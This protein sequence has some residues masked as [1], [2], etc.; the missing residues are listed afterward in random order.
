MPVLQITTNRTV[1]NTDQLAEQASS[2]TAEMLGK[3]ESYVMVSINDDANL[4]FAGT[5]DPC[6]HLILKS[7]GLPESETRAYSE[8]LCGFIEQQLGVPPS[9]TYIEFISPE[10]HMFGWDKRTF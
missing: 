9:R 4:I 8:K 6:A 2:L 1:D 10:R 7:L 3:P 5:K